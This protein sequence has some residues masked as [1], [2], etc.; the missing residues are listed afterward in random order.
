MVEVVLAMAEYDYFIGMMTSA[1]EDAV[2]EAAEPD[3]GAAGLDDVDD[4]GG[5]M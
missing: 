5:F 1:A 2:E 3:G 4:P